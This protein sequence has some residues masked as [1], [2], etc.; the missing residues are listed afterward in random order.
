MFENDRR[1]FHLSLRDW[2]G[3]GARSLPSDLPE[4]MR[5]DSVFGTRRI[6]YRLHFYSFQF[7]LF[8]LMVITMGDFDATTCFER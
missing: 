7:L 5:P 6:V 3:I 8:L 1:L 4:A 2:F